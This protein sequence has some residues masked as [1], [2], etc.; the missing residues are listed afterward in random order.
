[1]EPKY[2]IA[3]EIGSSKIRGAAGTV[4]DNGILT[5]IALEEERLIDCVR[6]GW[7]RNVE[8]VD[9]RIH[10][11]IK[12]LENRLH[13]RKIK[14]VYLGIGGLSFM[15]S[16]REVCRRLPAPEEFTEDILADLRQEAFNLPV[17]DREVVDVIGRRFYIDRTLENQPIGVYG[18]DIKAEFNIVTCRPQPKQVVNRVVADRLRLGINGFVVR[19]IAE[20]DMVITNEEKMLGC[21]LVDFGAETTGVSVYKSGHLQYFATLPL[22]SRNITLDITALNCLEEKAEE[23]KK[24]GGN[25]MGERQTSSLIPDSVNYDEINSYVGAR[26][27]EIIANINEQIKYA[28]YGPSQLPAGII[29]VGAGAKLSRFNERLETETKLPVRIGTPLDCIRFLDGR[30]QGP[31]AV[32]VISVLYAAARK[33]ARECMEKPQ[34]AVVSQPQSAQPDVQTTQ[35]QEDEQ[36]T[37]KPVEDSDPDI[38]DERPRRKKAGSRFFSKIKDFTTNFLN[39]DPYDDD[40]DDNK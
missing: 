3:I 39:D 12:K 4:D 31:D 21:V 20:G 19:Q 38:E 26:A 40:F 8:E 17:G 25:A 24:I 13:P 23:Y 29:I 36:P 27:G 10:R 33:G 35:L 14:S 5:V 11:I 28:G 22:G 1:M 6:Y 32:D 18:Q 9:S 30:I 7:I 34:P 37:S 15:S 16:P 2:V